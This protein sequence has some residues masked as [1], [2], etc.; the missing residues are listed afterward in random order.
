MNF[1]FGEHG[2]DDRQE[3]AFIARGAGHGRDGLIVRGLADHIVEKLLIG[4]HG[5][6][7]EHAPAGFEHA[8]HLTHREGHIFGVVDGKAAGGEIEAV[9]FEGEG[10]VEVQI[11]KGDAGAA[12]GVFGAGLGQQ[13]LVHVAAGDSGAALEVGVIREALFACAAAHIQNIHAGLKFEQIEHPGVNVT[14]AELVVDVDAGGQIAGGFLIVNFHRSSR[15]RIELGTALQLYRIYPRLT[16]AREHLPR[17][18][19]QQARAADL[20]AQQHAAGVLGLHRAD[21]GCLGAVGVGA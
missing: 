15:K 18:F 19:V 16:N 14:P 8:V 17:Q 12:F 5:A 20:G 7:E 10:F 9:V 2:A 4:G 13:F 6:G 21:M 3:L 1:D 11:H